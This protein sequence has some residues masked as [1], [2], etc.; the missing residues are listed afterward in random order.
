MFSPVIDLVEALLSRGAKMDVLTKDGGTMLHAAVS[1]EFHCCRF[2]Y[3]S[4]C[5]F[6]FRYA[7]DSG[8]LH[9]AVSGEFRVS[10]SGMLY[11]KMFI[12]TDV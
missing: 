8:E 1:G 5:M 2:S 11:N 12:H 10:V 9:A 6:R 3:V 4:C 7:P